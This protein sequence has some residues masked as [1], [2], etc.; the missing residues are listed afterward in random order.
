MPPRRRGSW[1]PH[2]MAGREGQDGRQPGARGGLSPPHLPDAW[3]HYLGQSQVKN[4]IFH[5]QFN[6]PLFFGLQQGPNKGN[7]HHNQYA[8]VSTPPSEGSQPLHQ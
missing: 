5:F 7:Y 6:Y 2:C 1:L 3:G 8:S 4:G